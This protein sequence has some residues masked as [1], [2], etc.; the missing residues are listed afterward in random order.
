MNKT[1]NKRIAKN[2]LLLHIRLFLSLIINLYTS[3]VILEVL[4]VEDYG[5]YNIIAGVVATFAFM[6]YTMGSATSRFITFELGLPN[7]GAIDKVF[8]SS[9]TAHIIIAILVFVLCETLG[10]WL[11][12]DKLVIPS[13]LFYIAHILFQLSVCCII[14]SII[15][16]PYMATII[17]N[18]KMNVYAYIEII[19]VSLKLLIVYLLLIIE[20]NKLLTYGVLVLF[21]SLIVASVYIIYCK[22]K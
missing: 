6:S 7:N 1:T 3:R 9:V 22:K 4:G 20:Y 5:V 18:E 10:L 15:Q 8:S 11:L 2:T 21:V 13:D 17:A 12:N 16:A 14:L 19:N